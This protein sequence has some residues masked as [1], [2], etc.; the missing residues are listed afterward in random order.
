M[1]RRRGGVHLS[2]QHRHSSAGVPADRA[3][4][5]LVGT[6]VRGMLHGRRHGADEV[7]RR[8]EHARREPHAPILCGVLLWVQVHGAAVLSGLLLRGNVLHCREGRDSNR[9]L[10][11]ALQR[12]RERH[13][14][15]TV[16]QLDLHRGGPHGNDGGGAGGARRTERER[17]RPSEEVHRGQ[18]LLRAGQAWGHRR[19]REGSG[20]PH[21]GVVSRRERARR[22]GGGLFLGATAARRREEFR[23]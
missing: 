6:D 21:R 18:Q 23:H 17:R 9:H 14:R 10:Q 4:V 8:Q 13:L 22:S 12:R 20:R 5:D 19:V 2:P 3:T 7:P 15:W 1:E 11:H 16:V